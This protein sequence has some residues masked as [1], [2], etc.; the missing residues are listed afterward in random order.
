MLGVLLA[1]LFS[2]RGS[3][4]PERE[5]TNGE[6]LKFVAATRHPA[7]EYWVNGRV[8][9]GKDNEPVVLVSFH[10]VY[11]SWRFV[12]RRLPTVDEWKSTCEAGKRK[13]A[14]IFGSGPQPTSILVGKLTKPCAARLTHAIARTDICR[15]GKTK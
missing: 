11:G 2:R 7:P 13:S 8:P 15:S 12:G 3:V 4:G 9:A 6:Y 1:G 10:D 5:V 14:A